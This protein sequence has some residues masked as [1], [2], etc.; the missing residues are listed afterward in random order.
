VLLHL[1]RELGPHEAGAGLKYEAGKRDGGEERGG[2]GAGAL[3]LF[4]CVRED[5]GI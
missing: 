3:F 2:G 1:Q 5:A 4:S